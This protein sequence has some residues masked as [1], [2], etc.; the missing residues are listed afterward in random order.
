MR[1][2]AAPLR[3]GRGTNKNP[4][5]PRRYSLGQTFLSF[6][7]DIFLLETGAAAVLYAP[8]AAPRCAGRDAGDD[9]HPAAWVL[10]AQWVKFM[11]CSG[12]VKVTAARPTSVRPTSP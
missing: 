3:I 6:Q 2:L 5:R 10:R 7:W 9:G 4:R 12:V 8:W 1:T 11:L